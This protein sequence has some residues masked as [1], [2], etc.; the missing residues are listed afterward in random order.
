M[1]KSR[2]PM[3]CPTWREPFGEEPG[4]R[5]WTPTELW[6]T[7]FWAAILEEDSPAPWRV[8]ADTAWNPNLPRLA[9]LKLPISEL[10]TWLLFWATV[11]KRFATQ[12]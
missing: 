8:P 5:P 11:L 6:S 3:E 2:Q 4:P 9:M 1:T 10:N 7:A 12:Q